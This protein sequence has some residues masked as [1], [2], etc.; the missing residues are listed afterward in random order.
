MGLTSESMGMKLHIDKSDCTN[1]DADLTVA[2]AGNPNVG[3]ST[4]FNELTGLNQHTGN[5]SGKTVGGA[6]GICKF[7][8]KIIRI[9]DLPGTYSLKSNSPE[10]VVAADY[11]CFGN[12]DCVAVVC[13]ATCLE[14]NLNL[15][16]QTKEICKNVVVCVNLIDEAR[17]KNIQINFQKLSEILGTPVIP[18]SARGKKG[19]K[20]FLNKITTLVESDF[21][22]INYPLQ[23]ENSLQSLTKTIIASAD[24]RKINPRWIAI[25]FLENDL[26]TVRKISEYINFDLLNSEDIKKS[27]ALE[28]RNISP[29]RMSD[30]AA[31]CSV[32]MAEYIYGEVIE[33]T[34]LT[35]KRREERLDKILTGKK[36][37]I[38]IMLGLLFVIF[39][40]TI[41]G[42]NYPSAILGKALFLIEDWLEYSFMAMN[43]PEWLT[44]AIVH[45][46]YR[47]LAWVVSV[48][49]P[50]MAIFFP[51]FTILED[52]GYL[53]R[54]AF[55]LD[56][57]FQKA[58]TCGKQALTICMGFGCNAAGVVGCR[59]IES[60]R[61]RLIAVLT[62]NFV[63]CNGRYPTLIAIITMFFI[64][65]ISG[66][67]GTI[68]STLLLL[69]IVVL[70]IIMTFL[71]S[72]LL[73]R[74]LLKGVPSSFALE[75][76]PY[77]PPQIGRIIV[78]SL[79]DRTLYVLGRAVVASIPAG[80][81]IWILANVTSNG[82]SLLTICS[83]FLNP[84]ATLFG[85]DG[86]ILMAF[87]LGFPA[88]EIVIPIIIM[89]YMQ[90]GTLIEYGSLAELKTLLVDNGWTFCTAISMMTFCLFHWPCATTCMTIKHETKGMKWTVLSAVLPTLIGLSICF[91]LNTIYKI[92]GL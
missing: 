6:F 44:G 89:A 66:F 24:C 45:G 50:P 63:P 83:D 5:W 82:S 70:G 57:Y 73:S 77:R 36:T 74:T 64:G 2:L 76:P 87:I 37:G 20:N 7:E 9:V 30:A 90:G 11:I 69:L 12:A 33:N 38:L 8:K 21:L 16:I 86:V 49:L 18:M 61:E 43:A 51:L 75:L 4:L 26:E 48:M 10:E 39:W 15:V 92:I 47:V 34:G 46:G 22:K 32:L 55:N 28:R 31:S 14:R 85:L 79:Y 19:I 40:L 17:R 25:K 65:G 54:V 68:F 78:R 23:I 3:K 27:L 13:D 59:I 88:N 71:I 42:S 53:P 41:S 1:V 35:N 67:F 58:E 60:P 84:I 91:I 81:I 72:K 29:K 52:A 62:N 80:I 56:H